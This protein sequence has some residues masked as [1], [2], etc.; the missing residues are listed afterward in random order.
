MAAAQELPTAEAARVWLARLLVPVTGFMLLLGALV[1]STGSG[2]AA[3]D[4]PTAFGE[5][6][7]QLRGG[8]LYEH[9]HRL[10]G[11]VLGFL[12]MAFAAWTWRV[13]PRPPIRR[14]SVVLLVL[15][16]AQGLLGMLTVRYQ[17]K[18]PWISVFHALGGPAVFCLAIVQAMGVHEAHP[19]L[20]QTAG[21]RGLR[22]LAGLALVVAFSQLFLGALLR[23]YRTADG[24]VAHLV[25]AVFVVITQW[26]LLG[27]VF[28]RHRA[29]PPIESLGVA[30]VLVLCFQ[31]FLGFAALVLKYLT[32]RDPEPHWTIVVS[33][34]AHVL[35]G[36]LLLGFTTAMAVRAARLGHPLLAADAQPSVTP[37]LA[38]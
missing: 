11:M 35:G 13:D 38:P 26:L 15:V 20:R 8:L 22:T 16:V 17:L 18:Q 7:P 12:T 36:A 29:T 30:V 25:G 21:D 32:P 19:A 9:G 27:R 6:F 34:S 14:L 2:M 1:T 31:V 33:T 37:R 3:P 5:M 10:T 28:E 23:H 4:W 24:I